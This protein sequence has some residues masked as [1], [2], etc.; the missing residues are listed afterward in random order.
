MNL[1]CILGHDFEVIQV[2]N[3]YDYSYGA[4]SPSYSITYKCKRCKK[5]KTVSVFCKGFLFLKDVHTTGCQEKD[6]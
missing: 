3:Y 5:I 4:K 2:W 6:A 1:K